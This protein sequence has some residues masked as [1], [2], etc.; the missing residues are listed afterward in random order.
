[1]Q[2]YLDKFCSDC[3][4]LFSNIDL[5]AHSERSL[6]LE[7][8][9]HSKC[10]HKTSYVGLWMNTFHTLLQAS[11][12]ED[13]FPNPSPS[14]ESRPADQDS[15]TDVDVSSF[16]TEIRSELSEAGLSSRVGLTQDDTKGRSSTSNVRA[17]V[18]IPAQTAR[19]CED[20][21]DRKDGVPGGRE[22]GNEAVEATSSQ[23][24]E[25]NEAV[26]DI[27][28][29]DDAPEAHCWTSSDPAES[30]KATDDQHVLENQQCKQFVRDVIKA[31]LNPLYKIKVISREQYS[32]IA[33]R[34]AE[35]VIAK[36]MP[37]RRL[38]NKQESVETLVEAYVKRESGAKPT[39]TE[40]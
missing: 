7:D 5:L 28:T 10:S 20:G 22:V 23:H 38:K 16:P 12:I 31:R 25:L 9:L 33:R 6:Q 13:L 26:A 40:N 3:E 19:A 35:K 36:K 27:K 8:D 15:S 37:L 2:S 34:A 30:I 17:D 29:I 24:S 32:S 1:M 4:K 39:T 21:N 11:D 18:S 14:R